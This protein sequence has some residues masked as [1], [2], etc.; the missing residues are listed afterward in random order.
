MIP[1]SLYKKTIGLLPIFCVDIVIRDRAGRYLL[2]KR[3]NQ[4]LKGCYWVVGGRVHR[5]EL[6]NVAAQRKMHQE[7]GLRVKR[8][9]FRLVGY[10]EA[11]F[12]RNAFGTPTGVHTAS[13]VYCTEIEGSEPI[14]LDG[15][16]TTW[17]FSD[18]L[19]K[20]FKMQYLSML[21]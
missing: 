3:K 11:V 14:R 12:K 6:A 8:D 4:P 2:V 7:V 18:R 5:G 19:P 1:Q 21:V 9:R 17:K 10:T 15:Q 13:V 16:S 20:N